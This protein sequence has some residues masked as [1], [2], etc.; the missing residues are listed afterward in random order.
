MERCQ[1]F[2]V[3]DW[4]EHPHH[5][6][7]KQWVF[8]PGTASKQF[9]DDEGVERIWHLLKDAAFDRSNPLNPKELSTVSRFFLL[10]GLQGLHT[11]AENVKL[12]TFKLLD[13]KRNVIL[14]QR[15]PTR[16]RL[17]VLHAS[18]V[19]LVSTKT[20]QVAVSARGA[21]LVQLLLFWEPQVFLTVA[22]RKDP[23][24]WTEA[25]KHQSV[26]HA[27]K[28]WLAHSH[29][30]SKHC[31]QVT[32]HWPKY[33]AIRCDSCIFHAI[34]RHYTVGI[35]FSCAGLVMRF[36]LLPSTLKDNPSKVKRLL[37]SAACHTPLTAW[38][39]AGCVTL[40]PV[41]AWYVYSI[42]NE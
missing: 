7:W 20:L 9:P 42:Y 18:A 35:Y 31:S 12:D 3:F 24:T 5:V 8:F 32:W 37:G 6:H 26:F 19:H 22:A 39:P 33:N 16:T 4:K 40:C 14:V 15:A 29:Q 38:N 13:H 41:R 30:V 10:C 1:R 36:N 34:L 17:G 21:L 28:V 27:A 11:C 2:L 25:A 23:S